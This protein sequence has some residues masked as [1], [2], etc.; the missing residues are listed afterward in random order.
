LT[1]QNGV[2]YTQA[3]GHTEA[4]LD[5]DPLGYRHLR[6]N[7]YGNDQVKNLFIPVAG[8][9][10]ASGY[11]L[12]KPETGARALW[13]AAL[14]DAVRCAVRVPESKLGRDAIRWLH[15]DRQDVGSAAWVCDMLGLSLQTI[16]GTLARLD[17]PEGR[18]VLRYKPNARVGRQF[19]HL[20]VDTRRVA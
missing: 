19:M 12:V 13:L 2:C 16:R 3:M 6:D 1:G 9:E 5:P 7:G 10:N 4:V 17:M 8:E 14:K 20:S 11:Q 18:R 15:L